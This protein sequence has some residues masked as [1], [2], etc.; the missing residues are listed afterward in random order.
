[1]PKQ[2][3]TQNATITTA[4]VE[5]KTLTISGKQ[6]TLAVFRQLREDPLLDEWDASIIGAPWGAVNYHPD[7]CGDDPDHAHVVWQKGTELRRASVR[8]PHADGHRHI[9]ADLYVR[10][11]ILM[12]DAHNPW[13]APRSGDPL[14]LGERVSSSQWRQFGSGHFTHDGMRFEG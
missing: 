3:T 14:R 13:H 10:A 4:A 11:R 5:V 6:V 9:A 2:L 8:A 12:G 7:K 1:M